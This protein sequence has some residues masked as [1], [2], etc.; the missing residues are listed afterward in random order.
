[1]SEGV[2]DISVDD[3]NIASSRNFMDNFVQFKFYPPC[4]EM[5]TVAPKII[6]SIIQWLLRGK[7]NYLYGKVKYS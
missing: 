2:S 6:I 3:P 7:N 1:M 4:I 5:A